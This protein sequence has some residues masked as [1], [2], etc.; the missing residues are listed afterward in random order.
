MNYIDELIKNQKLLISKIKE[1]QSSEDDV[2][3][4][5]KGLYDKV[6][7]DNLLLKEYST[8]L[9]MDVYKLR[10]SLK[11]KDIEIERLNRLIPS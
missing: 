2:E 10:K 4:Y 9:E 1:L 7:K 5:Y 8:Q 6:N 11:E 3:S